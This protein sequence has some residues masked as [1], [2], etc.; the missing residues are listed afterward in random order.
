MNRY[1]V[2]KFLNRRGYFAGAYIL[3]SVEHA[4]A[5]ATAGYGIDT[6]MEITDCSRR[7]EL[8]FPMWSKGDRANS[9]AK[10]RL[11][12]EV[13]DRFADALEAEIE[14]VAQRPPPVEGDDDGL[15]DIRDLFEGPRD[16]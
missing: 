13:M 9:L 5:N 10:A 4:P 6:H 15:D 8:D 3:A 12:A 7:I 2:R 14:D 1:Y 11:L 16:A